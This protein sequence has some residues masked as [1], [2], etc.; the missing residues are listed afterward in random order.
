MLLLQQIQ[1]KIGKKAHRMLFCGFYQMFFFSWILKKI[2]RTVFLSVFFLRF[3]GLLSAIPSDI[4]YGIPAKILFRE[5]FNN[6]SRVFFSELFYNI[7]PG[8]PFRN[9]PQFFFLRFLPKFL[10]LFCYKIFMSF[11]EF[12]LSSNPSI[13]F[14]MSSFKKFP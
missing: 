2:F 4:S 14:S 12:Q 7:P 5:F 6:Y 1:K 10:L 3:S 8:A 13:F 9:F 11:F